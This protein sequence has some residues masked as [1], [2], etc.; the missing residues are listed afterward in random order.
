MSLQNY[1]RKDREHHRIL[2]T[3]KGS[4][5]RMNDLPPPPSQVTCALPPITA[6]QSLEMGKRRAFAPVRLG[7]QE[8]WHGSSCIAWGAARTVAP[9]T[10]FRGAQRLVLG[11][12]KP[13][14]VTGSLPVSD[15][16]VGCPVLCR[17][18]LHPGQAQTPCSAFSVDPLPLLDLHIG[19]L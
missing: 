6:A 18:P 12:P 13:H 7:V 2:S 16:G 10:T 1:L 19:I 11:R 17:C 9:Y 15:H 4:T 5:H 14:I 8:S 3:F